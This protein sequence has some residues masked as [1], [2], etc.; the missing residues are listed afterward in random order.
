MRSTQ[1]PP[2]R[3]LG[4]RNRERCVPSRRAQ[5]APSGPPCSPQS[6]TERRCSSQSTGAQNRRSVLT[7]AGAV[8]Q[9]KFASVG[10][11][12]RRRPYFRAFPPQRRAAPAP[13]PPPDISRGLISYPP[14]ILTDPASDESSAFDEAGTVARRLAVP[15]AASHPHRCLSRVVRRLL[16]RGSV[17]RCPGH[18]GVVPI[19]RLS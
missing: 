14:L 4:R 3:H 2:R 12:I 10:G 15:P 18:G 5:I 9:G 6:R 19:A 8:P 16:Q 13:T 17:L 7:S 11:E 1:R